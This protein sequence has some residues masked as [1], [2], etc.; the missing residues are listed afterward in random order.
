MTGSIRE[1]LADAAA[2]RVRALLD[3]MPRLAQA[4]ARPCGR[5]AI[6]ELR[7]AGAVRRYGELPA[8]AHQ[9]IQMLGSSH[10]ETAVAAGLRW[11]LLQAISGFEERFAASDLPA[12]LHAEF[13]RCLWRMLDEYDNPGQ[14][15]A[16]SPTNDRFLKDLAIT[17]LVLVPCAS[18]VIHR[19]SGIPRRALMRLRTVGNAVGVAGVVLGKARGLQPFLENHVHKAML[20]EFTPQG[21]ERCMRLVASLLEAWPDARGLIGTSWYYDPHVGRLSPRLAYL[22]QEPAMRGACFID[23]GPNSEATGGALSRSQTRRTAHAAGVYQ[24]RNYMMIWAR[25]DILRHYGSI[26]MSA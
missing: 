23:M 1:S 20:D 6:T 2:A 3:Q 17:R 14:L 12:S 9:L 26:G 7:T 24:P 11:L 19:H 21:R 10:G 15:P 25:Q 13:D 5:A 16:P 18:H 4:T 22:H 8:A